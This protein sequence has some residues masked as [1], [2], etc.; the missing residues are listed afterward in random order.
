VKTIFKLS[1][2]DGREETRFAAMISDILI[3][4][5]WPVIA[6]IDSSKETTRTWWMI[7]C[8]LSIIPVTAIFHH[9]LFYRPTCILNPFGPDYDL[10]TMLVW[11][12]RDPSLPWAILAMYVCMLVVYVFW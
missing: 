7:A 10:H 1:K 6:P 12:S 2:L 3:P 11:L 8:T 4:I 5:F 9:L